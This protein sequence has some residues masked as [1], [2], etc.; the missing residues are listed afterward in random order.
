MNQHDY[1]R[2]WPLHLKATRGQSLS[3]ADRQFYADWLRR[4]QDTECAPTEL[5][6]LGAAKRAIAELE[7]Q[8]AALRARR[9]ELESEISATEAALSERTRQLLGVKE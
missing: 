1:D 2:W 4:L 6:A 9:D 5:P 8:E 7:Q 3:D